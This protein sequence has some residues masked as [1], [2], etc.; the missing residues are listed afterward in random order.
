MADRM[1]QGGIAERP[2]IGHQ[3]E[4]G[5]L[6]GAAQA[7]SD[8]AQSVASVAERAWETTSAEA[9]HAASAVAHKAEDAWDSVHN[10]MSRNPV[11]VFF[12]G[13]ALGALV[14]MA[15]DRR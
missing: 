6:S 4:P 8:V 12:T 9:Q 5:I 7:T 2:Y 15:F 1:N 13:I 10:C 14:A 3:R 11:A